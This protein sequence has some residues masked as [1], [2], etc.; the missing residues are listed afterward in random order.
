MILFFQ[1]YVSISF[2]IEHKLPAS[3]LYIQ[4]IDFN[5]IV[6]DR[7]LDGKIPLTVGNSSNPRFTM[8]DIDAFQFLSCFK[9]SYFSI[10]N[11]SRLGRGFIPVSYFIHLIF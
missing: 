5:R 8:N 7:K 3:L 11:N 4:S 1:F 9:I 6:S 10:Q 2:S